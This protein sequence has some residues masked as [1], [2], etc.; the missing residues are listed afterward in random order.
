MPSE[1]AKSRLLPIVFG[2][3]LIFL[4]V[5]I[6]VSCA[7]CERDVLPHFAAVSGWHDMVDIRLMH[8]LL[9][10]LR[11]D[12]HILCAP[13]FEDSD[14]DRE[15]AGELAEWEDIVRIRVHDG[16]EYAPSWILGWQSNGTLL[17][18]GIVL[19]LLG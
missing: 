1:H 8:L 10:G 9:V 11:A 7:V 2:L 17:A 19:S 16:G 15:L 4:I 6:L 18:A 5:C 13:C 3:V 14:Y 12:G